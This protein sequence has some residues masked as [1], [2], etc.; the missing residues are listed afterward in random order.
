MDRP[1]IPITSLVIMTVVAGAARAEKAIID[2]PP[3]QEAIAFQATIE[4]QSDMPAPPDTPWYVVLKGTTPVLITAPHATKPYREGD[5]RFS[6][7]AGTA[8]LAK[9]LNA[10]TCATVI[11][12]QYRSPSDPNFY[13]NNDFKAEIAKVIENQ[14]PRLLLDLHGSSS[15]RPYDVDLGT[16]N[17]VSLLGKSDIVPALKEALRNEGLE[18][19]SDNY[20]PAAK[21]QTITR[22]ASQRGVPGIQL[23][24]NSSWLL[25][26]SGA[27]YAQRF[28]QLAQ[29]IT[30]Y[31]RV[32]TDNPTGTCR[33]D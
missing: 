9:L 20:F 30:R 26:S 21:N 1:N 10:L 29:G 32:S 24:I 4:A 22:F 16:M 7:G 19:F 14:K 3:M 25:P 23:E 5:F 27:L 11:Y 28:S 17:G 13:D 8:A 18:N 33:S 2:L 31:I 6:D 12:T 15:L